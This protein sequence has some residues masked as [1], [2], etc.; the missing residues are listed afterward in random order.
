VE[1]IKES[2]H[3]WPV[4]EL[5]KVFAELRIDVRKL[6]AWW[7]QAQTPFSFSMEELKCAFTGEKPSPKFWLACEEGVH[8]AVADRLIR[9]VLPHHVVG[10]KCLAALARYLRHR[11]LETIV[12]TRREN[13]AFTLKNYPMAPAVV[14][15]TTSLALGAIGKGV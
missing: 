13:L 10:D 12:K 14:A 3:P 6:A 1:S 5:E 7:L 15:L 9:F 11:N 4:A 2:A 8:D